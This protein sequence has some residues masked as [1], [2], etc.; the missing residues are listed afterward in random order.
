MLRMSIVDYELIKEIPGYKVILK[1]I[2]KSQIQQLVDQLSSYAEEE[3]VMVTAN[4]ADGTLGQLGSPA[5][6]QFLGDHEQLKSQ[7]LGFCVKKMNSKVIRGSATSK[8]PAQTVVVTRSHGKSLV[9]RH[10]PYTI[11]RPSR[12]QKPSSIQPR[13]PKTRK[14][15]SDMSL[16]DLEM[17]KEDMKEELDADS[18]DDRGLNADSNHAPNVKVEALPGS[19]ME[20][21]TAYLDSMEMNPDPSTST[22]HRGHK[23]NNK[24]GLQEAEKDRKAIQKDDGKAG[25]KADGIGGLKADGIDCSEEEYDEDA[26]YKADEEEDLDAEG[27]S[28]G[29]GPSAGKEH[30]GEEVFTGSARNKR[31]LSKSCTP[32]ICP[33]CNKNFSFQ[34]QLREHLVVHT[35][36]SQYGCTSCGVS[37][38]FRSNLNR[39]FKSKHANLS[40]TCTYCDKTFA[41]KDTL[42]FHNVNS[43]KDELEKSNYS[44]TR[45][46]ETMSVTSAGQAHV[47]AGKSSETIALELESME[48]LRKM[49]NKG[50]FCDYCG[51]MF[52]KVSMLEAH[53][54]VHTK[55][56]RFYCEKCGKG[57]T[58]RSGHLSHKISAHSAEGKYCCD[59]CGKCFI[60]NSKLKRHKMAHAAGRKGYYCHECMKKCQTWKN[61]VNHLRTAHIAIIDE[62]SQEVTS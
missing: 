42:L 44:V 30:S 47:T 14:S 9:I 61:L 37:F 6:K 45:T 48:Y 32:I 20:V 4:V 36:Q 35:G 52:N 7:F 1:A 53:L 62:L 18:E 54:V 28:A 38:K 23:Y 17:D 56:K 21:N 31:K 43:H 8:S 57:F 46:G 16:S 27:Q 40:F 60:S 49:E 55:E 24:D 41:R 5:G 15:E 29:E 51:K 22:A 25:L 12:T 3:S 13:A 59:V 39:H 50:L 19:Q 11:S 33:V 34:F 58:T 10:E 2:L 26:I